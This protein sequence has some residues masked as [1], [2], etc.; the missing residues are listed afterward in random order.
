MQHYRQWSAA[1]ASYFTF[2][3]LWTAF[4][5][6]SL[7]A[8]NPQ[9]AP[10][11]LAAITLVYFVATPF[12]RRLWTLLGFART[13]VLM[14]GGVCLALCTAALAPQWMAWCIPLAFFFG[15]GSYT[16]CETPEVRHQF[17]ENRI[18]PAP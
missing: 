1:F 18:S 8:T 6:V 13:V 10:A 5:P 14:G 17:P 7:M 9:A 15:S 2:L 4:G 3:G 12:V 11:A 16:V